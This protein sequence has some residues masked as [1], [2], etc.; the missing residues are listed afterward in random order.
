[1]AKVI[2][3]LS[4]EIGASQKQLVETASLR[5]VQFCAA[6]KVMNDPMMKLGLDKL[7]RLAL[8]GN[9]TDSGAVLMSL[10]DKRI[11]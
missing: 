1:M 7:L 4:V 8:S 2:Q 11:Q 5:I 9:K 6:L 3:F 10:G